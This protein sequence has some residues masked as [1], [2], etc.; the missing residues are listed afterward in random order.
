MDKNKIK[1]NYRL[2]IIIVTGIGLYL[3]FK[4]ISV[5]TG[6]L[7][8]TIQSNIF[9]FLF[10]VFDLIHRLRNDSIECKNYHLWKGMVT[11]CITLTMVIYTLLVLSGSMHS[12]DGHLIECLFVHYITPILV[13]IDSIVFDKK[14][15]TKWS[16][17]LIWSIP[18]LLYGI[19]HFIYVTL[20]GVFF[21][22]TYAYEFLNIEKYGIIHV[23]INCMVI[24]VCFVV[25]TYV[26]VYYEKNK[27][28][29]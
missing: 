28:R 7:Y 24:Y 29:K 17:P 18:M 23:L 11:S 19:F 4:F 27:G 5:R 3:N 25:C 22:N 26:V 10:Y 14:E 8:F 9:C 20:G 2:L 16:Y 12:Y 1:K 21:D 6:I 13:L 15:D